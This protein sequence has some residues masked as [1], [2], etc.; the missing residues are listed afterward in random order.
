M[1]LLKSSANAYIFANWIMLSTA[2]DFADTKGLIRICKSKKNRQL[3]MVVACLGRYFQSKNVTCCYWNRQ[4]IDNARQMGFYAWCRTGG[5]PW[6]LFQKEASFV[7]KF[8]STA[9]T[10]SIF[11]V[12]APRY[13]VKLYFD[14]GNYSVQYN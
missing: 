6:R 12:L 11:A 13:Q 9:L 5:K 4:P 1:L 3:A 7:L 14:A 2:L 8:T 10:V